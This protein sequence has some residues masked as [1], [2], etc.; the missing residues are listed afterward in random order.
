MPGERR[1]LM[2]VVFGVESR[3]SDTILR[4]D[5]SGQFWQHGAACALAYHSALGTTGI[6]QSR[7]G[8]ISVGKV[9]VSRDAGERRRLAQALSPGCWERSNRQLKY[10]YMPTTGCWIFPICLP[11]S[12]F[13][14]QLPLAN[15]LRGR[16]ATH[17]LSRWFADDPPE[18]ALLALLEQA[19]APLCFVEE[20][21]ARRYHNKALPLA[22][23]RKKP[24]FAS[25]AAWR[26]WAR[27]MRCAPVWKNP[28]AGDPQYVALIATILHRCMYYTGMVI[29]EHFRARRELPGESGSICT[30][31]TKRPKNGAW[32]TRRSK[33]LESRSAGH[34]LR[35]RLRHAA[36]DRHCQ[37]Y[38]NS[39]RDLN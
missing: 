5:Q 32:P 11:A 10:E 20:E 38:S 1:F 31:S 24:I 12:D 33:M 8:A 4:Q 13:L 22:D 7:S 29:F 23:E 18:P 35:R 36:A 34:A 17:A 25:S 9:L 39:V 26:R 37:P 21:M 14:S 2:R 30:A 15:P 28:D 6:S 16:T 19:R 3:A 27:P